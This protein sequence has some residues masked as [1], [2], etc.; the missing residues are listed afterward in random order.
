MWDSEPTR[1]YEECLLK[2]RLLTAPSPRFRLLE[3][4]LWQGPERGFAL[5]GRHLDRLAASARFFGF[6]DPGEAARRR[7]WTWAEG[8]TSG[9][10]RVRLLFDR[11]GRTTIEDGPMDSGAP[12]RGRPWL[13]AV[14]DHP[15]DPGDRFLRHKT[16]WRRV[17]DV[18]R[19][20]W[21]GH[22][23]VLLVNRDGELTESTVANLVVLLEGTLLTPRAAAGLLPGTLRAELLEGG[24]ILEA[25]LDVEDLRRSQAAWLINSVRGWIQTEVPA[26]GLR[27]AP[28]PP[29]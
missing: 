28:P 22:D 26:A 14:D 29:L 9:D 10:R 4:L 19:R 27:P 5:L 7:L 18:A 17:Y 20:R 12:A 3:T 25:R 16:T 24:K 11:R 2:A 8:R 1:E 23:D 13:A 15:V 6:P 21:P